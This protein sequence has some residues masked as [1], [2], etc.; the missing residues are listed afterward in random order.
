MASKGYDPEKDVLCDVAAETAVKD[1]GFG[2]IVIRTSDMD[3][4]TQEIYEA[5][6]MRWEID[7]MFD[8]MRNV[9]AND[10][11]YMHDD[12]GFE[13]WSFVGHVTLMVACRVLALLK[14]KKL[15][16]QWSLAD[17]MDHLSRIHAVLVADEWKVAETT[18]KTRELI[19]KPGFELPSQVAYH[20]N[21]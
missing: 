2:V 11:S 12:A 3:A 10:A 13:A 18:K 19:A 21:D 7:Q 8:T 1:A 20:P 17:V 16:K 5:Y 15:A 9:C 4:T 6:K 14:N